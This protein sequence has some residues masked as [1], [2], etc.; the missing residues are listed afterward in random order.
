MV[1]AVFLLFLCEAWCE[2]LCDDLC[3]AWCLCEDFG[4]SDAGASPCARAAIEPAVSPKAK[5]AAL[6]RDADLIIQ[7][8]NCE[9]FERAKRYAVS[10]GLFLHDDLFTKD[11]V[12]IIC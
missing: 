2:D 1:L 10:V 5:I 12:A 7:S 4:A 8:P 9:I 6:I 3:E 11:I